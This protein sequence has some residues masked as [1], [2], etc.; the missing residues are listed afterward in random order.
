MTVETALATQ[1]Y[2]LYIK[3][4]PEQIWEAI[5]TPELHAKFFFGAR[6]ESTFEV[7][8]RMRS[9]SPDHEQIWG[10]NVIEECDPPK[11]LVHSWKSL[12]DEELAAE[13]DS[14]VSWQ[15]EPQDG[16]YCKL[17]VIHDR[18]EGAP[19]TAKSVSG[20]WTF[21]LSGLKTVV[22]TGE[23]LGPRP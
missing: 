1:V 11:K 22:E 8:A 17:T 6:I 14:R 15:I 18:L 9:W 12:Y 10:D 13:A 5:T 21:I 3:G 20:G 4:T 23:S 2:Q 16:G 19:K 7:G